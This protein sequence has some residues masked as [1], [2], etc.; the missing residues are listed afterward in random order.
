MQETG[1]EED[2]E[3]QGRGDGSHRE[4]DSAEN[5]LPLRGEPSV[6]VRDE[7]CALSRS[8]YYEW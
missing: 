4:A 3:T 7:G 8:H 5:Q 6:R 2:K 1:E